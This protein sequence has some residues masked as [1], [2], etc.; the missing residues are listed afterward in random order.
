MRLG[1]GLVEITRPAAP[2]PA[3]AVMANAEVAENKRYCGNCGKPVGRSA[4][5]T[6]ASVEGTCANCGAAF[7]FA[8][9]L[10]AGE[11][12]GGQYE[13]L[14]C[15]AHGGLGWIYLAKDRN[16][17]DRWVVLKGLI[18]TGDPSAVAAAVAEQR[19]LAEVEHPN[20][21][22]IYNFVEHPDPKSGNQVGYIVMEYIG[23]Q[24][25]RDLSMENV[26]ASGAHTPL[27]LAQVLA[28]ALE[29]LPALGYLHSTGLLYCDLKP[30]NVIQTHE[31]LK[32]IDLGAVRRM[33]DQESPIFFT[34]GY[35]A[36]ELATEGP[37]VASDI[38]TVGRMLAVLSFNFSGYTSQYQY[39]LPGT[40]QVPL[41]S[42]FESFHRLLRRAT[43]T[44][45]DTRFASCEEMA[46]QVA[47]VLREVIALSTR[48][49]RP[50]RSVG[51]GAEL[52]TF[53]SEIMT[54]GEHSAAP[55]PPDWSEV[56]SGL[57]K[58]QVDT[59]DPAAG[60]L[61]TITTSDPQE[62]LATLA[63]APSNS[64]E[65]K[66]ARARVRIELGDL[67]RAFA[68]INEAA[69]IRTDADDVPLP[70]NFRVNW[71]R[72]L[73]GLAARRPRDARA[74]FDAVYDMVAGELAPKLALA[75]SA[76]Y[77]GDF[78]GAARLYELV[79]H[80]DHGYVS[81]A[82]GLARVYLAQGDRL[83]AL[84][85]LESVPDR[86]SQYLPAQLAAI[87]ARTRG[88]PADQLT[89]RD[90]LIASTRLERL[91]LDAERRLSTSLS[92]LH[93]AHDWV[94]S[95]AGAQVG[96]ASGKVLGYPLTD[97]DLRFGLENCYRS[98]ARL[99]TTSPER[100]SLVDRANAIRPRT[101]T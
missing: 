16:V 96:R 13:V 36:P 20:I 101:R 70:P 54:V 72:G 30:D 5:G 56:T 50:G 24:S 3:S 37:S 85:V 63:T 67:N 14:G 75:I 98:M 86:S 69:A 17:S 88:V 34:A 73:L 92:V 1:G 94:R 33:D 47:G 40:G 93:A 10:F 95:P 97:R 43:A 9:K 59:S 77:C 64:V 79:W 87:S 66:L 58:P 19:F 78:F 52:R 21:V 22:K 60:V 100:H 49:P 7:S 6:P 31:G 65:A 80:T 90:L 99:A 42:L 46:E 12:V 4:G 57:P 55:R 39:T 61:G 35:S 53:G 45:P 29:V 89:E 48:E 74:A 76:E 2:D 81:A 15:L 68:D 25:L 83:G 62:L 82:F 41:F 71:Y 26:D 8:P 18:D 32:L 27:P 51:F 38:Y 28:Y 11:L 23:G 84:D 91:R 44:D